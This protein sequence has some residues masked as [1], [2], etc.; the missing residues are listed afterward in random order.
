MTG[1]ERAKLVRRRRIFSKYLIL[2]G[3]ICE[4]LLTFSLLVLGMTLTG[5]IAVILLTTGTLLLAVNYM[6]GTVLVWGHISP[7][8]SIIISFILTVM[9]TC[10]TSLLCH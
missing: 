5:S 8:R 7:I 9:T 2:L 1:K 10:L 6:L 4:L 3:V